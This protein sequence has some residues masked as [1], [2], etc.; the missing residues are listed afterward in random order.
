MSISEIMLPRVRLAFPKLWKAEA[1]D[2]QS[3]PKF[4]G[5]FLFPKDNTE[6]A[7][8]VKAVTKAVAL[9]KWGGKMDDATFRKGVKFRVL[10]DGEDKAKYD[11]FTGNYF[12]SATNAKRPLIIDRDRSQLAEVDGRPYAGCYVNAKIEVW[13][14]DNKWGKA[15]N[16]SLLGVQYYDEGDSFGG[17][18]TARADEFGDVDAEE[19]TAKANGASA[20]AAAATNDD[21]DWGDAVDPM[22]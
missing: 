16:A 4:G 7:A 6:L 10:Q 13:A 15:L 12:V 9:A 1:M 17:G 14:Q 21:G 2:A 22:S 19:G 8:K 18:R 20:P 5:L 3:V 11:G